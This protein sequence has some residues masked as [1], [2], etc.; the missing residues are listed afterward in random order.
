MN[1]D[2]LSFENIK[3]S[4]DII[5]EIWKLDPSQ[6]DYIDSAKLSSYAVALSQY[7]IYFTFQRNKTKAEIHDL[8][9]YVDRAVSLRL[10]ESAD[11]LKRF[12]TK[13]AATDYLVSMDTSLMEAQTKLDSLDME[14][15][16]VDGIDKA[17]S[18]LI[19]TLKRELTRRE[20]ELYQVRL[21]RR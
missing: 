18:D 9:K 5:D 15:I 12:K 3:V 11:L 19:S 7:L 21:E 2:V 6:I 14:M 8:N 20:N 13:V 16:R 17:V 4:H 1:N 10:S